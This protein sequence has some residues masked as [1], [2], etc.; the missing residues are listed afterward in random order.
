MLLRQEQLTSDEWISL[1]EIVRE[2][3]NPILD[4]F[5][6]PRFGDLGCIH[7]EEDDDRYHRI[8]DDSPEIT[9]T[10]LSLNTHGIAY[11]ADF[12]RC[13]KIGETRLQP[14]WGLTKS[15][16]W[17]VITAMVRLIASKRVGFTREKVEDVCI[18]PH[19][20]GDMLRLTQIKPLSVWRSIFLEISTWDARRLKSYQDSHKVLQ[21]FETLNDIITGI[22]LS[23]RPAA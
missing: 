4:K 22:V 20:L 19:T 5:T 3:L 16:E 2:E 14:A 9:N 23:P 11:F 12:G 15:G 8:F 17:V 7:S 1:L 10:L 21:K 18:Y 6:L 13:V